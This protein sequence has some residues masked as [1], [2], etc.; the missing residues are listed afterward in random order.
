MD[1]M[2]DNADSFNG[3][4]SSWNVSSVTS[5]ASMF[6]NND[7]FNGD[8]SSWDVSNVATI[9]YMFY[10]AESF[11]Q[12]IGGWDV[13]NI[14]DMRGVFGNASSFNNSKIVIDNEVMTIADGGV[15]G[16]TIT[17]SRGQSS[18]SAATHTIADFL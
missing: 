6:Y 10:N 12:D 9:S 8:I 7:S 2:F 1:A 3:D 4:I 14:T 11:N 16:T 15:S 17:V 5:M 13:S 18:T